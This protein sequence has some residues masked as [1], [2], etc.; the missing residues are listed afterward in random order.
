MATARN[1]RYDLPRVVSV[2]VGTPSTLKLSWGDLP[3]IR[4]TETLDENRVN[5]DGHW[6]AQPTWR[7]F[8]GPTENLSHQ[9]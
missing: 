5:I 9:Q 7:E 8:G 3:P 1:F 4:R 2:D 6:L